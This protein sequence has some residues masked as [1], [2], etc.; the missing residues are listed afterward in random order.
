MI[1]N[2]LETKGMLDPE[3]V[4]RSGGEM[5]ISNFLLWQ[6]AYSEIFVTEVLWPE[7]KTDNLIDAIREFQT[8]ERRF[9]LVSE[10]IENKRKS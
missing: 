4:I 6:I 1:S 5:R 8:R 3:L 10:Q 2:N 7:F 9:G